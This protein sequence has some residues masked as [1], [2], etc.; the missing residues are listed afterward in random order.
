MLLTGCRVAIEQC[1]EALGQGRILDDVEESA[2][3]ILAARAIV[4]KRALL[5]H[6][7]K[8]RDVFDSRGGDADLGMIEVRTKTPSKADLLPIPIAGRSDLNRSRHDQ[9]VTPA[10]DRRLRGRRRDS[11]LGPPCGGAQGTPAEY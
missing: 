6:V 1:R 2:A 4:G 7:S 9:L 11:R 3:S 5:I 8:D 10:T